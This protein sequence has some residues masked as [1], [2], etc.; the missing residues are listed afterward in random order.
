MQEEFDKA[1]GMQGD[2]R[3]GVFH[4]VLELKLEK[5]GSETIAMFPIAKHSC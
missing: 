5:M 2:K 4:L 3:E 1:C